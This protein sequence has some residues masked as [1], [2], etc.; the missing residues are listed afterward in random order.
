ML[1]QTNPT[2]AL[3]TEF[4]TINSDMLSALGLPSGHFPSGYLTKPLYSSFLSPHT[5][6]CSA[7]LSLLD[8]QEAEDTVD[9]NIT[10]RCY[11]EVA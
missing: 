6:T 2:D 5:A 4:F 8:P 1:S 9:L 3:Q 11:M 7:H 10:W